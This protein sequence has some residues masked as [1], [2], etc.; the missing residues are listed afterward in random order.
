MRCFPPQAIH[1][2]SGLFLA[3][4]GAL[5]LLN[6]FDIAP[7]DVSGT[8]PEGSPHEASA[9]ASY[10]DDWPVRGAGINSSFGSQ[11]ESANSS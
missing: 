10:N 9:R 6:F 1:D 3:G 11:F 2:G 8:M 5:P 4:G 7:L